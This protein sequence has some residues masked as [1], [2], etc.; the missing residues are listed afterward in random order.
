MLTALVE[1]CG[2]QNL[3]FQKFFFNGNLLGEDLL[4][5][6][7]G[8]L[9]SAVDNVALQTLRR[10]VFFCLCGYFVIYNRH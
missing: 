2:L 3:C 8:S 7:A 5:Q 10:W 6:H 4:L 1:A 9:L